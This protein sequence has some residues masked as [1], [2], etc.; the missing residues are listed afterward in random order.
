M[1]VSDLTHP[2][3]GLMKP[4]EGLAQI[5]TKGEKLGEGKE[6]QMIDEGGSLD[7]KSMFMKRAGR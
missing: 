4:G 2:T 6:Q 1:E 7:L 5:L 3:S